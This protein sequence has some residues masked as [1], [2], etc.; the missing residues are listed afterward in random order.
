MRPAMG[1]PQSQLASFLVYLGAE[2]QLAAH[3][4][5]AYRRDVARLLD[6]RATLPDRAAILAH[7]AALRRDHA[8]A[9]VV[10]A[11]AAIRG[12]F[13]F[14]HGEGT[15][16]QD[17]TDGL[18]GVRLEQRLPKALGRAAIERLLAATPGDGPLRLRDRALL[19]VLYATGCRVTEAATLPL[20]AWDVER[21]F[22]RV[23]G[24]GDK[25]RWVP[26]SDRAAAEVARYLAEVRPRLQRSGREREQLFLS[27]SGRPLE[28]V[29]IWQIVHAAAL[30][31]GVHAACSPHALRHS[32]ATHLVEGGADLRVVQELL[33]HA[34]LGTTQVYTKV[35]LRRM[36]AAHERF[37]PRG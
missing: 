17:P 35:E 24:K 1:D 22:V 2:L 31:A 13:R 20:S 28:R 11:I 16:A 25:E 36:K 34:S 23:R 15:V 29:R 12:F 6:G 27:R 14:L 30:R 8:P 4:V 18:L 9:S 21:R 26:V 3:T 19:H 10:R 37:H 7:L 33:G 5:A 32:F